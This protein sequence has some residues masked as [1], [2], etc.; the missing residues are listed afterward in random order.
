MTKTAFVFPGQG[1][2]S[3]GMGK[4]SFDTDK[5]I[6]GVYRK[7]DEIFA[8]FHKDTDI[9]LK[10]ISAVSFTG[11][12][13]LL[14]RTIYTQP[15]ILT[16]S[17][18]LASKLKELIKQRSINSPAYVAGHSLGEFAALYMADVLSLEDVIKLVAKRADLMERAPAGA[19]SAIV[20][21]EEAQ[22]GELLV[23]TQGASV[24]NYNAPDQIVITGTKEGVAALGNKINDYATQNALKVRV[25]PL[26]VGGAFHSPLMKAASD[27][28]AKL[29]DACNFNNAT[30]PVIQNINA[31]P[32]TDAATIKANL[33]Q[34]MCGSVRWTQ[35][36]K[37]LL[38]RPSEVE[39]IWEI[40]PGKVLAGLV[41]KQERRFSVKNIASTTEL[42]AAINPAIVV[43]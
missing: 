38:A 35:T 3:V 22:L 15:A 9:P 33:K 40:G 23:G 5:D 41:K 7:A 17:I 43:G 21:M 34:Q 19:M 8:K 6:Q 26:N 11:P 12:E 42:E 20:G 10:S 24:A 14:T 32:V 30:I 28:F 13:D 27:E 2:Q 36:V 39:E 25:I 18:A 31:E 37:F 4:E 29:I 1:A 16:L